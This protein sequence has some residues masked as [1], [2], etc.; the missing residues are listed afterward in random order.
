VWNGYAR[1][2]LRTSVGLIGWATSFLLGWALLLIL[3]QDYF[4]T[5]SPVDMAQQFEALLARQGVTGVDIPSDMFLSMEEWEE[6]RERVSQTDYGLLAHQVFLNTFA[7]SLIT[8]GLLLF[9]WRKLLRTREFYADAGVV[10]VQRD[11]TPLMQV[12]VQSAIQEDTSM[13]PP[14]VQRARHLWGK[15]WVW[16]PTAHPTIQHR[17]ECLRDPGQVYGSWFGTAALIGLFVMVIE[18][19]LAGTS[20][21]F[22]YGNWPLH[23]PVL[24]IVLLVSLFM[25]VS[26]VEGRSVWRESLKIVT[27]AFI[28]H[29]LLLL[30]TLV[31][32]WLLLLMLPAYLED[33][34][35]TAASSIAGYI[36]LNAGDAFSGGE[37]FGYVAGATFINLL[38]VPVM[39]LLTLGTV[40]LNIWL[41]RH[42]LTWYQ[43]GT[44]QQQIMRIVYG[45][46]SFSSL[47]LA[48][49]VL[50]IVTD[51]VL[52]RFE[53]VFSPWLWLMGAAALLTGGA[54]GTWFWHQHR[55]YACKCPHCGANVSGIYHT[56]RA[57][58]TCHHTLHPW[59]LVN[60]AR[61][62]KS[63]ASDG[64]T[65]LFD[66]NDRRSSS[67]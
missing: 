35:D 25:V 5:H 6:L 38:Q 12:V 9:L 56:G 30:L 45:A 41:V 63:E 22:Y 13:L 8:G 20:A 53:A 51:I 7:L 37:L 47:V 15:L 1:A 16:L 57:C 31:I 28:P 2:L 10:H 67:T 24:A 23:F 43:V 17:Q 65:H 26:L 40:W 21:L 11:M 18:L 39:V 60:Y 42:I 29:I 64:R 50:P 52:L 32:L 62:G 3:A 44:G 19:L 59:L 58:A 48:F 54:G 36:G 55:L 61:I 49:G 27:V 46:I 33:M 66:Q 34:L 4:I 14:W